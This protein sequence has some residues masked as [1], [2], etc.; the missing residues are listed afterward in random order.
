LKS[1]YSTSKTSDI[2]RDLFRKPNE[3]ERGSNLVYSVSGGAVNIN[4]LLQENYQN[5]AQKNNLIKLL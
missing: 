4:Q 5:K 2:H 1:T 3:S